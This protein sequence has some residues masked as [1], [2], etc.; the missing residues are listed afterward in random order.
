MAQGGPG[1]S[2]AAVA[3]WLLGCA[4]AAGVAART[5]YV[6][7]LSA[8]LPSAPTAE[9]AVLLDQLKRGA[10]SRLVLAGIEGGDPAA[11]A[12]AS[13]RLA[14]AL[15]ASG[16]FA[17]VDNGDTVPWQK[18]GRFVFEHRYALSPAVD[19]ARFTSEGLRAAIDDTLSLLGTPAGS[20]VKPILFRDPT[21]ET[22]RIAEALTP[23]QAPR[24]EN[25]V[26]VSRVAPRAVL[27]MT[28]RADGAD[29]DGQE[30]ALAT[31][32]D[33]FAKIAPGSSGTSP[34]LRL[35]LSGAGSF[36]V[37]A[38]ERIKAE[39]ERLAVLGSVLM[40]A[41][42]WLAFASLRSLAVAALP[43]ATG[44]LAGIAG[45]S[46]GFGQVHGMTLGFG[47]TLIG[48]GVD[49][50]IYYLVQTRAA[51][52]E[53]GRDGAAGRWLRES[54]PTVRLGLFTSLVGFAALVFAG[55]PGLAQLGVFSIAG[56]AAAAVTTR[57]VFPAIAPNGAPGEGMR[58]RLGRFM[59]RAAEVLP[60]GRWA[61]AVMAVLAALALPLLPSPWR[62][63]LSD[64]SPIS[65]L[66]L[67]LD[68]ALRADV[69]APDA[70]MLVAVAAVD[71]AGALATA[72]A[73]GTRLDGLVRAGVLAG[74]DS[75]ARFLPSPQTQR[76]RLASLPDAATL[77]S[78]LA[79][80]TEGGALPA[81]RLQAFIDD[82]EAARRAAPFDR[83]ALAGT[84]LAAAV[85]ALLLQGDATRPWRAL[86]NLQPAAGQP[87][88]AGRVRAAIAGV[89][90]AQLVG[91][92]VEL[93]ALYARY[94]RQAMWQAG[95]GAL[96]VVALLALH[97]R[98][99]RRLFAVLLP[100][101]AATLIVLAALAASGAALG[102]LHLVGLLLTVA[103]GSNYALFF[104]HLRE[105]PA[106]DEDTLASLLLA[107]LATVISFGLLATSHI[108]V[109]RAVGEVVAP[110]TLLCLV[111]AAAFIAR[112]RERA[113]IR[114]P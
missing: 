104:D 8:F 13:Q 3:A 98:R 43:V 49:Y 93:D 16:L 57:F 54:W 17:S 14:A 82:V 32:R 11:R 92:K 77:A 15:R 70:G 4:I 7:D 101:A 75:P 76:G 29:L 44:V 55:F 111:F 39:V 88:D 85:D 96:A 26:W 30:Q 78:R 33:A 42:L 114:R 94:L 64:L 89:P 63:S 27:V 19:A 41:L 60:R 99:P 12:A 37:A 80:A 6:A 95:L 53:A 91:I 50:A 28:T 52:G 84:P 5:H 10:A 86:L 56:L 69:G 107:N 103:I 23:A 71:Q 36:G 73:V 48:E 66:D 81:A 61:F 87:I 74:Y 58:R 24:S 51:A 106:V 9:Q 2:R 20:L 68:A 67:K 40:T 35:E 90:G 113:K 31:I 100:L 59:A 65:A 38:R 22:V 72:E 108:P 79:S 46:L 25:G 45:V 110:G 102:I 109:L 62:G 21:G 83:A 112:P 47:T 105:R 97:L 34:A 1:R 18:A